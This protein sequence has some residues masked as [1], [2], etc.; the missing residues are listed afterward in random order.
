MW[1]RLCLTLV[2]FLV[3]FL[4]LQFY[5][6]GSRVGTTA[7][8]CKWE[9]PTTPIVRRVSMGENYATLLER[10]GDL[11]KNREVCKFFCFSNGM[12]WFRGSINWILKVC[13]KYFVCVIV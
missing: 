8:I 9:D 7:E 2:T 3:T 4:L 5:F 10:I 1:P 13:I 6:L 11:I 12:V